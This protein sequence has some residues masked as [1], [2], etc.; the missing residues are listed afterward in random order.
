M[1]IS[2]NV[3]INNQKKGK[4]GHIESRGALRKRDVYVLSFPMPQKTPFKVLILSGGF[5][6]DDILLCFLGII[7]RLA[8]MGVA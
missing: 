5:C 4:R 7:R 8:D 3:G 1:N 6:V 2:L